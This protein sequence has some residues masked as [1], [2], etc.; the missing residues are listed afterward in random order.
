M[1]YFFFLLNKSNLYFTLTA[2]L[3]LT[4]RIVLSRLVWWGLPYRTLQFGSLSVLF[5][6]F[7]LII[8]KTH[9]KHSSS[10]SLPPVRVRSFSLSCLCY[11]SI[12]IVFLNLVNPTTFIL[13]VMTILRCTLVAPCLVNGKLDLQAC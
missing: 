1:F 5:S 7:I 2:C 4:S 13:V 8:P 11:F 9:L 3:S 6:M 10:C 12:L